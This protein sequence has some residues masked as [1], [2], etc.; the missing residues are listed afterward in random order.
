MMIL[1]TS[2]LLVLTDRRKIRMT[3]QGRQAKKTPG[4]NI[5]IMNSNSKPAGCETPS[6]G[7]GSPVNRRDSMTQKPKL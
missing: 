7:C 5:S 3:R 4:T 1:C 6:C 2:V